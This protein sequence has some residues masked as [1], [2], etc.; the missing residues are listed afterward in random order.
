MI[1]QPKSVFV[2]DL[3]GVI[4]DPKDSQV[5][6]AVIDKMYQ[7]LES[8]DPLAIN[9]GRSF[10]WV[11][12][13]LVSRL[14]ARQ[15]E[16]IFQRFIVAC[17]K[18]GETIAWQGSEPLITPSEFALSNSLYERARECFEKNESKLQTMFWD[19]TKRTMATVEKKPAANLDIFHEEQ[20]LLVD[21]LTDNLAGYGVR[22]DATTIATDVELP[23]AGKHAGASLIFQ[24]MQ[25]YYPSYTAYISIGD[26]VS[27]YEM[28][29]YFADHGEQS[30]FVYVGKPT[31]KIDQD[32]RTKL[33][34]TT[35]HYTAGVLEYFS[36]V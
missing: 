27:D 9:T 25:T 33:V 6:E 28:A 22:I 20:Q 4:T 26:S 34:T 35:E 11:E 23:A 7:V 31:D 14:K 10:D 17:E 2:F 15:N 13:N 3:D 5:N 16:E 12:K 8:G 19:E 1:N 32:Q 30:T 24:W 36:E 18:G 21:V 29:R